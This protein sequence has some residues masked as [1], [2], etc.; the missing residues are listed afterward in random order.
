MRMAGV[1][2]RTPLCIVGGEVA[3]SSAPTVM[4]IWVTS[5]AERA[6]AT[7]RMSGIASTRLAAR[8]HAISF[9]RRMS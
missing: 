1:T 4:D 5:S 3:K 8:T 2:C 6:S 7:V 9:V